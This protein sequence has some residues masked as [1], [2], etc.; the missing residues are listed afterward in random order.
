MLHEFDV[1]GI[2][3]DGRPFQ[4]WACTRQ[5]ADVV[6][7]Q[8]LAADCRVVRLWHRNWELLRWTDGDLWGDVPKK[9][10]G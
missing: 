8:A 9:G 3:A 5:R 6:I 4:Y 2:Q 1:T 7:E 10:E